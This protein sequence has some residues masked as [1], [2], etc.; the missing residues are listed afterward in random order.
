MVLT[1][2]ARWTVSGVPGRQKLL[3]ACPDLSKPQRPLYMNE[4][5][6][7]KSMTSKDLPA[8]LRDPYSHLQVNRTL[9]LPAT[10]GRPAE[11]ITQVCESWACA[12]AKAALVYSCK[13]SNELY[14]IFKDAR[15][16]SISMVSAGGGVHQV[17]AAGPRT[18]ASG[19]CDAIRCAPCTWLP[20]CARLC[21]PCA[22]MP[23]AP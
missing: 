3:Q 10:H 12:N 16:S 11:T 6:L 19:H 21:A 1:L 22:A 4:K 14:G 9:T 15:M 8:M 5:D 23:A 13:I 17:A 20:S 18:G 2:Q 7:F